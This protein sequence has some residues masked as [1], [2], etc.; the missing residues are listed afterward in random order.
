MRSASSAMAVRAMRQAST[1]ASWPSGTRRERKRSGRWSHARS[2]GASCGDWGGTGTRVTFG[3]G[4]S[5]LAP[6]QPAPS[7]PMTAG[8]SPARVPATRSRKIRIV[9]VLPAAGP[10]RRRLRHRAGRRRRGRPSRGAD[11]EFRASACRAPTS[12]DRVA[13]VSPTRLFAGKTLPPERFPVRAQR[14][15][16]TRLGDQTSC[17]RAASAEWSPPLSTWFSRS[18]SSIFARRRAASSGAKGPRAGDSRQVSSGAS[19]LSKRSSIRR[20][21]CKRRLR[22][23]GHSA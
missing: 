19:R 5:A 21:G 1:I 23:T 18:G 9:S 22:P 20:Q 10:A 17:G 3:G 12:D 6:C 2:I 11:P 13:L 15:M 8:S 4:A 7:S 16:Y 14:D